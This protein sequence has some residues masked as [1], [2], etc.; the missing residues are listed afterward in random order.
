MTV[1]VDRRAQRH[2]PLEHRAAELAAL[3]GQARLVEE[4]FLAQQNLRTDAAEAGGM[5]LPGPN[6]VTGDEHRAALWLG[7]DEW[8]LIGV[9]AGTEH[10]SAVDVSAARTT[11]RLRGPAAREVLA[12]LCSLD[13][14]PRVFGPGQVAQTSI[15]RAQ[16]VLWQL[17]AE[18]TYRLLVRN[19]FAEHLAAALLDAIHHLG[20]AAPAFPSGTTSADDLAAGPD[21]LHNEE[22]FG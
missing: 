5:R 17:D 7:P 4:P 14:H 3:R 1:R 22:Q 2:S 11:L 8:L 9:T 13:L 18:P 21:V 10:R 19:S 16:V 6:R 15:A 20:A 12:A